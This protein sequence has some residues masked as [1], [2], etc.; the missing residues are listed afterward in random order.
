MIPWKLSSLPIG[1]FYTIEEA[2]YIDYLCEVKS[3]NNLNWNISKTYQALLNTNYMIE[4]KNTKE[5][6]VPTGLVFPTIP[7]YIIIGISII[8]L[9]LKGGGILG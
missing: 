1:T 7:Y 9:L 4:Y 3:F 6:S 8:M 5:I 2:N